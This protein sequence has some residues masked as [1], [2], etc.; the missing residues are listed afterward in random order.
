MIKAT[1]SCIN[2][3]Q[4]KSIPNEKL[5]EY[6]SLDQHGELDLCSD[7]QKLWS[8]AVKK[9]RDDRAKEFSELQKRFNII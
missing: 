8:I 4:E 5:E 3:K 2:C 9:M 6:V 7:C 1:M